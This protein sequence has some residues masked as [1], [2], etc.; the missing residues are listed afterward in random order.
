[1]NADDLY[2]KGRL[3]MEA[4]E[5]QDAISAFHRS[6]AEWPHFKTL[7]LLAECLLRLNQPREAIVPLAAATA[8]NP[9]ARAPALLARAFLE[10]G[11]YGDASDQ[12]EEALRRDPANKQA[13]EVRRA[14]RQHLEV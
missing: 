11:T 3:A 5:L 4:G 7:E 10:L 13:L 12:A 6:I 2:H 14:A 8:L 1:M 9:Q